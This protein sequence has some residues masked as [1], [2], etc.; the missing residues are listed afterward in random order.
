MMAQNYPSLAYSNEMR[1][2]DPP[3]DEDRFEKL[4]SLIFGG[5]GGT[6]DGMSAITREE[7]DAKL[8]LSETRVEKSLAD[9]KAEL[10]GLRGDFKTSFASVPSKGFLVGTALAIVGAVIGAMALG[11]TQFGNGV[12][13]TTVAIQNS[14]DAKRI[15]EE[16]KAAVDAMRTELST[17]ISDFRQLPGWKT[18]P[19]QQ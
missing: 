2:D 14:Q 7:M 1:K 6:F 16:N 17:F 3:A 9:M 8:S 12:M 5:G 4:S 15:A 11:Y 19:P 13:V 18:A 10:V